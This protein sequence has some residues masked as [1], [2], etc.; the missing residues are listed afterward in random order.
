MSKRNMVWLAVVV[1]V[2]V[3]A[4]LSLGI[5]AGLVAA[6][7]TLAVSEVVE[8]RARAQ[9]RQAPTDAA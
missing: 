5:V 2:G 1:A 6:A 3:I 7:V 8:R 9:R 4:W